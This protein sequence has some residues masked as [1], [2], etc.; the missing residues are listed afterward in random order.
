MVN[1]KAKVGANCRI[2]HCVT[3]GAAD[4]THIPPKIGNNVFI[5][6]GAVIVGAIEIADGVAIGANSFF[7]KSFL[8]P[9][10][11]IAGTPARK[12]SESAPE[13]IFIRAT[14]ILNTSVDL[15][16]PNSKS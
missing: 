16:K 11:T 4:V 12:I 8:E 5:G 3:I 15:N 6:P 9:G 14:E 10:I 13:G 7:N 2:S 1:S